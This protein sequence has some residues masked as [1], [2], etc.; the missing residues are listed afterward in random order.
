[1]LVVPAEAAER[2]RGLDQGTEHGGAIVLDELD[3]SGLEDQ[4]A[5]LDEVTGPRASLGPPVANAAQGTALEQARDRL[6]IPPQ[7]PKAGPEFARER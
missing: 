2:V 1:M 6:L 7:C 4:P 3:Q 5:E